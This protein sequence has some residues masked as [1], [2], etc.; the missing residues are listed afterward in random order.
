MTRKLAAI[1]V[2]D[3]V[4]YSRLAGAD[5]DRILARL[6]TL[7]SDLVDPTIAVHNGRV[8]KRTG[9]GSLIEFRSVVDA[10]RCAIE[11]QTAMVERNIGV[12]PEH[13]IEFRV[14]IHLGDVVE[15][16]DGDLMGDGVNI[17]AR[18]EGVAKPGAICLSEDAYRQVKARLD[19]AVT[20]LGKIELK[21]IAE[22]MQVY[23]LQ[24]GTPQ[25]SPAR[26]VQPAIK[27]P[28]VP[29]APDKPSI[30]VLA[31]N[32]MSGDAEQEYFSDG[33][34]EDIIT[35]LSKLSELHVIARNSSFVY[36]NVTAS[37]PEMAK[38]LGVRYVLE[39][40]VRKA[41]NR[42]RV[43]AQLID[44][45]NGGHIWASRFDRDLTDI[46]AVQDELTQEIVAALRLN[47]THGDQ[48]RLAQ[49]RAL[50]VDAYELLLRGREQASAHT[51][52]GNMAARSLAADALAIDPQYAAAQALISFTHVLDYVNAWSTDPEGSLRIGMDL[53][54]QAVEMAEEQPNGR[55]ALGM[56]CMWNR[57]LDRARAEVQQGLALS[58]NSA[59]LLILLA[60]IQIFSGDPAG[61]LE[62]LDAS[63]RLDPH[64][65]EILFQFRADAHVSLG[66]YEQAIVAIEQRLQQNSQSETAYALLAS[67]YGH[68]GRPEESRQAWEKALRINPDF[69]VERRRRILPFR[70]PEDFNRRVEGLRKAGLTTADLG[71]C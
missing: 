1:L 30:A 22:P 9:D 56:A 64:H 19:L 7:R 43:T 26:Q 18:L 39:G 53:A 67:C 63:M 25:P 61:A 10:V 34:S 55:F 20:D 46:F 6:R 36:K 70:N 28:S 33:I 52:T 54:Q 4:G 8:V 35:D 14:G 59:D 24:I 29:A 32:N 45:S 44:A 5:E 40:S 60:H 57:E 27:M 71:P 31:F 49:G 3:V 66:E 11:V 16:N 50:N 37:V 12:S 13:R 17:A 65:P 62:T 42:V 2:A 41:G 69:S 21:N 38:A 15:E 68:L 47:L 51:R 58:P 48:D 23:S